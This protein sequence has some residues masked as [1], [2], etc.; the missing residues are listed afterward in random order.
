MQQFD[1]TNPDEFINIL[2]NQTNTSGDPN[3]KGNIAS[4]DATS[5]LPVGGRYQGYNAAKMLLPAEFMNLVNQYATQAALAPHERD[6]LMSY[7]EFA[8]HPDRMAADQRQRLF[9]QVPEMTARLQ[10]QIASA[11]GGQ[12]AK[13]GAAV[14][15]FNNQRRAANDFDANL[16]SP[17]GRAQNAMGVIGVANAANP[18]LN[19]LGTLHGIE[20]GTPRNQSGLQAAGG[21]IGNAVSNWL[22][23]GGGLFSGASGGSR[24]GSGWDGVHNSGYPGDTGG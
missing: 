6:A 16:F 13:E 8:T 2:E 24:A 9:A 23:P 17:Q 4:Y 22:S 7:L 14:S 20:T 19:N 1:P 5:G 21:I 12:A 3:Y 15:V 18:N 10:S 11:G